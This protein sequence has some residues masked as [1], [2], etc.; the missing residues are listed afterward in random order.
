MCCRSLPGVFGCP[1]VIDFGQ[2]TGPSPN[3]FLCLRT[4]LCFLFHTPSSF[5]G[6]IVGTRHSPESRHTFI[7]NLRPKP[8]ECNGLG[9]VAQGGTR[10]MHFILPQPSV[11]SVV[12]PSYPRLSPGTGWRV[13]CYLQSWTFV[14]CPC[15]IC[16]CRHFIEW[17]SDAL[18]NPTLSERRNL[19]KAYG[20]WAE[21]TEVN[22]EDPCPAFYVGV[23]QSGNETK[24]FH[25]TLSWLE[26]WAINFFWN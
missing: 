20:S 16:R 17:Y 21:V 6:H 3:A 4:E 18:T 12:F 13:C 25:P 23:G 2:L 11:L 10:E 24:C 9:H 14:L 26:F 7:P 19:R 8:V 15:R 1:N 5:H 22:P